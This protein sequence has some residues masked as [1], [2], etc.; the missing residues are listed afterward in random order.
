MVK[1][2]KLRSGSDTKVSGQGS[3]PQEVTSSV[4][5]HWIN[6]ALEDD[7]VCEALKRIALDRMNNVRPN[8]GK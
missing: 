5:E 3:L 8:Q 7:D 4:R 2:A 6:D 1:D